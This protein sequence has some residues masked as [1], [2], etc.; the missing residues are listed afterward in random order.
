M[1]QSMMPICY[2]PLLVSGVSPR[3][4]EHQLCVLDFVKSFFSPI[5]TTT[6]INTTRLDM[7]IWSWST[8]QF[9]DIPTCMHFGP[10]RG[11]S[12]PSSY[13][14]ALSPSCVGMRCIDDT[15]WNGIIPYH[16]DNLPKKEGTLGERETALQLWWQSASWHFLILFYLLFYFNYDGE[17][18]WIW[19]VL[20]LNFFFFLVLHLHRCTHQLLTV[21]PANT[22][23][24]SLSCGLNCRE[25]QP[26]PTT[27]IND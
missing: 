17:N 12:V 2:N 20:R 16:T 27:P 7:I 14:R 8:D 5:T 25:N 3:T 15:V 22:T 11:T 9:L 1:E 6:T 21:L 18:D 19:F 23:D 10:L 13:G 4:M 24:F 26:L